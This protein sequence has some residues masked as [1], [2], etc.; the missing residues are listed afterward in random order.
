MM[1]SVPGVISSARSGCHRFVRALDRHC[2]DPGAGGERMLPLGWSICVPC[3]LSLWSQGFSTR[4]GRSRSRG[5]KRGVDQDMVTVRSFS[6]LR[7]AQPH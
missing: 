5:R 1:V 7:M 3:S 2:R 6:L 4:R